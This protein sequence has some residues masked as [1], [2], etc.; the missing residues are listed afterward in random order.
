MAGKKSKPKFEQPAPA[1]S[2]APDKP[3]GL[4]RAVQKAGYGTREFTSGMVEDGRLSVD[5]QVITD[6][7]HTVGPDSQILLDEKPLKPVR[8]TYFAFNKPPRVVCNPADGAD[9]RQVLEYLPPDIPGLATAGRM[10]SRTTGLILV[11]NDAGWNT[12]LAGSVQLEHEYRVQIEGELSDVELNVITGGIQMPNLGHFRPA[13][14][15]IVEVLNGRT[16]LM[17]VTKGTKARAVR[18]MFSTLRHKITMLRRV[19]IGDIRLGNMPSGGVRLLGQQEVENMR[20]KFTN[21]P[22]GKV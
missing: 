22:S 19:R 11:S 8:P 15:T 16:V 10:D 9:R 2:W 5:G 21:S 17:I 18:R 1:R 7:A 3:M 20:R 4:A 13:S 12:E 6:P 14:V